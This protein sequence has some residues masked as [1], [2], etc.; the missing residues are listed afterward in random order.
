MG[1]RFHYFIQDY[2]LFFWRGTRSVGKQA[3]AYLRGL[4]QASRKNMERMEEVVPGCDYQSLHH[5]LSHSEWDARAVL[6]QVAVQADRHLGGAVDS[7]LLLDESAFA[8]KGDKSVGVA[9]QWS[10]RLG[11][12][13]NCQVAVFACL[14]QGQSSTL[15]D[16]R[17]YLPREWTNDP[18]RCEKAGVP[19]HEAVFRSKADLAFEMVLRARKNGVRFQW[20]GVDGGYG[21]EPSFLRRLEDH[22]EV[23]V[24]EVHKD[25]QVYMEDPAPRLPE[26]TSPRGRKPT[27]LEAQT[28]SLRV[29]EWV[30]AQTEEN[31]QKVTIRPGTKGQIRVEALHAH[32]W[33]WNGAEPKAR[34]WHFVATRELGSRKTLK[35]MLSNA[36]E[37]TPLKRLVQ[38][39][40]QRFWIE[41]SFED[42]KSE[43]GMA[44][45]QVRGWLAWHHHIA[46]VT[47]A[48]LFMLEEKLL[49]KQK[50]PLLSC[51]DIE[52]LLAHFLPRRDV[53]VE[54]VVRQLEARH[55]ARQ[56][57]IN[58]SY[59]RQGLCD[60]ES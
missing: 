16:A 25:Q 28:A 44:D 8:K 56:A 12:V 37:E 38:M 46:L 57:A 27:R 31:W 36:P 49:H 14:A 54:E 50:Y 35:Y 33:L 15:I 41:R 45:Y 52:N 40:R 48:M 21:K 51:S 13:D 19:E 11:K 58:S 60:S 10:G 1:F 17:L 30:K 55:R 7:C 5:F 2:D 42:A 43:S 59:R 29:D 20:V 24:A 22:G 34:H 3:E 39:Q 9:R 4:M 32:V 23:F 47:M 6:N 26:K 53:T 18:A